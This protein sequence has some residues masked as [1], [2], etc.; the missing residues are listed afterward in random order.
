M[1]RR[2]VGASAPL[3]TACPLGVIF[4]GNAFSAVLRYEKDGGQHPMAADLWQP[5]WL[6]M[7]KKELVWPK[8]AETVAA[9]HEYI[10]GIES[11]LGCDSVEEQRRTA[12][13]HGHFFDLLDKEGKEGVVA[14]CE[15]TPA[16]TPLD[17]RARPALDSLPPPSAP[18]SCHRRGRRL[19]G[20]EGAPAAG[21][22]LDGRPGAIGRL[23]LEAALG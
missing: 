18:S 9:A 17:P 20:A 10:Q 12:N 8:R 3:F 11:P 19:L 14:A 7:A 23:E 2:D 4:G 15:C 21:E 16:A 1:R 5:P 13:A 22:H 6:D